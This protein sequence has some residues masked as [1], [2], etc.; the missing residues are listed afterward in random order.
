[1]SGADRRLRSGVKPR[2]DGHPRADRKNDP[3]VTAEIL[4]DECETEDTDL[5][6]VIQSVIENMLTD[7]IFV[8]KLVHCIK[9]KLLHD[10]H[11]TLCEE[12]KKSLDF[13]IESRD[14]KITELEC[15]VKDLK[16]AMDDAEQYTR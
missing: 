4:N 11:E 1:M 6:C 16:A 5:S 13:E 14:A 2:A 10:V 9:A 15:Q 8:T 3:V 7:S 12:V